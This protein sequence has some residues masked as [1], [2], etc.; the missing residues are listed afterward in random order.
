MFCYKCKCLFCFCQETLDYYTKN[1]VLVQ[2]HCG[3]RPKENEEI[4]KLIDG[5]LKEGEKQGEAAAEEAI[6]DIFGEEP[7]Y[8]LDGLECNEEIDKLIDGTLKEGDEQGEAA[9]EET[10]LDILGEESLYEL[11]GKDSSEEEDQTTTPPPPK[12]KKRHLNKNFKNF[13]C[14]LFYTF[15]VKTTYIIEPLNH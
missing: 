6:L 14:L 8:E 3:G 7:L 12:K 13:M 1:G 4:D 10:I 2:P 5:T 9:A 15:T 11:D